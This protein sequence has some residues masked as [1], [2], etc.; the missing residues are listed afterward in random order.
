MRRLP[1]PR[2]QDNRGVQ[3]FKRPQV[4]VL[5]TG[6]E[7]V[8]ID[9]TPGPTQIPTQQLFA[10]GADSECRRRARSAG[11]RT[12][13]PQK[14]RTLIEEGL[15]SDLLLMTGESPWA[16]R[17]GRAS[18]EELKA[19]FFFT[20]ARSNPAAQLFSAG[21][22]RAPRPRKHGDLFLRPSRESSLDDGD[23]EL[24]ARPMLEA[25]SGMFLKKLR[26]VYA[27]LKSEIR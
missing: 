19:E 27:K 2:R 20:G 12:D 25:L 16:L 14:L 6:D 23:I 21:V 10:G 8:S 24:F 17:P 11:D 1:W 5:T 4:A 22:A 3:V 26:F 15:K 9:A 13:E 18:P 7:I